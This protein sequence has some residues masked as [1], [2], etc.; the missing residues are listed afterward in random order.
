MRECLYFPGE[1][2]RPDWKIHNAVDSG[3]SSSSH[4]GVKPGNYINSRPKN[5]HK[6]REK[7][8]TGKVFGDVI[9]RGTSNTKLGATAARCN[10]D[11][12]AFHMSVDTDGG[13]RNRES[14][15][16]VE[17]EA[18]ADGGGYADLFVRPDCRVLEK[19]GGPA[20]NFI[21]SNNSQEPDGPVN[22]EGCNTLNTRPKVVCCSNCGQSAQRP[23]GPSISSVSFAIG[24]TE[25]GQESKRR[26]NHPKFKPKQNGHIQP[27]VKL[28]VGGRQISCGGLMRRKKTKSANTSNNKTSSL[29]GSE[30]RT[31]GLPGGS[32]SD[33]N[34]ENM[35]RLILQNDCKM[36]A[37]E[38]W[39]VG[40]QLGAVYEGK[41]CELLCRFE[42]MEARDLQEW[43]NLARAEQEGDGNKV[44]C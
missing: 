9:D 14:E 25:H 24:K 5:T 16:L 13:R 6:P 38:I 32:I 35:N 37:T 18:I 10:D 19:A 15:G 12:L 30:Q 4:G 28:G 17:G 29:N 3:F 1:D 39:D 21:N 43:S 20:T 22:V 27:T 8:V 36:T 31:E 11:I 2:C 26:G 23:V 41:E 40:K 44:L 7:Q 34:I 42:N 33:S